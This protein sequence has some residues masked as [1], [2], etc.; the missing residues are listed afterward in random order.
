MINKK[1]IISSIIAILILTLVSC[2]LDKMY[3]KYSYDLKSINNNSKLKLNATYLSQKYLKGVFSIEKRNNPFIAFEK[4]DLLQ[5]T[6]KISIDNNFNDKFFYF[7]NTKV[8]LTFKDKNNNILFTIKP[9]GYKIIRDYYFVKKESFN[10]SDVDFQQFIKK[11]K[12]YFPDN[13][14]LYKLNGNSKLE[15]Y[16]TFLIKKRW[17]VENNIDNVYLIIYIMDENMRASNK[18]IFEFP[19][20]YVMEEKNIN[21]T[22]EKEIKEVK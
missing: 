20:K 3:S 1:F 16:E 18:F 2:S 5:L 22:E 6:F 9:L 14:K 10:F 12:D 17:L 11:L 7:D 15:K 13:R 4:N 19:L 21:H 8:Y